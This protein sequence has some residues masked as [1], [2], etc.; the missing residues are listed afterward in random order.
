RKFDMAGINMTSRHGAALE[1]AGAVEG[2]S[3][4]QDAWR[5]L[6]RNRAAVAS[7]VV[8]ALI[9][10]LSVFGPYVLPWGYDE[11][12][13]DHIEALPPSVELGHY[14]GTDYVGRDL[15]ART[16]VGGRISLTVGVLA[17]AV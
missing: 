10:L 13:W 4:W 15:L 5:R 11:I 1:T 16:L 9:A 14:L 12:D 8:L 2:R 3:L 6:L 17:T 7:L